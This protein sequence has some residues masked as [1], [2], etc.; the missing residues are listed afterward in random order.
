MAAG[1]SVEKRARWVDNQGLRHARGE[2]DGIAH[3][4]YVES[5]TI[6]TDHGW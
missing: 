4:W 2:I 6:N 1:K 5:H 3:H